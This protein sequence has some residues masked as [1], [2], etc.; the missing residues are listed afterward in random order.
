MRSTTT[1]AL[2]FSVLGSIAT[3]DDRYAATAPAAG[4]S[5]Q[6]VTETVPATLARTRAVSDVFATVRI[7]AVIGEDE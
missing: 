7:T 6:L 1:L 5:R 2:V 4:L 3:G